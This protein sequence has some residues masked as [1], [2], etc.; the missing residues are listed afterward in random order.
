[1]SYSIVCRVVRGRALQSTGAAQPF[2]SREES[3]CARRSPLDDYNL[4]N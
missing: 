2:F 4:N 1:M 3:V